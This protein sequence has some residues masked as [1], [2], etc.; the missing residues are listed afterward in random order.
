LYVTASHEKLVHIQLLLLVS[1]VT[2][3]I[4]YLYWTWC[5]H[6]FIQPQHW[7]WCQAVLVL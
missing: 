7:C 2:H 6:W 4:T 5:A 1:N 3:K